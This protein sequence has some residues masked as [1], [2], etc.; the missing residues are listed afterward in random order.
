MIPHSKLV[1]GLPRPDIALVCGRILVGLG[2]QTAGQRSMSM[3]EAS[4]PEFHMRII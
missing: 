2:R 1:I 4:P 3:I